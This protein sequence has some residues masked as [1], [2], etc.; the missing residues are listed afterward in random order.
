MKI[1]SG[2][3]IDEIQ[4]QSPVSKKCTASGHITPK[5]SLFHTNTMNEKKLKQS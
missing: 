4:F 5:V 1:A 3:C 2:C